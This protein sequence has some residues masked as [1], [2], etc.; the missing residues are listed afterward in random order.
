MNFL[1]AKTNNLADGVLKLADGYRERSS[2]YPLLTK[3]F[4]PFLND[5][6][7]RMVKGGA[8]LLE[9]CKRLVRL[10]KAKR[11]ISMMRWFAGCLT[12]CTASA[13]L[14]SCS[15]VIPENRA[16]RESAA[17]IMSFC[18]LAEF[19][20]VDRKVWRSI[21]HTVA[22][23]LAW[24]A[25]DTD[26]NARDRQ[27]AVVPNHQRRASAILAT[28]TEAWRGELYNNASSPK[29]GGGRR[30]KTRGRAVSI[31]AP[32]EGVLSCSPSTGRR[33]RGHGLPVDD[34][35]E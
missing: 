1:H 31:G 18:L 33:G 7:R 34:E 27:R 5:L 10:Q 30:E 24:P 28:C 15:S 22:S 8:T 4:Q 2:V 25:R 11:N 21:L 6:N 26:A 3:Q 16:A 20:R 35:V 12:I 32:Q 14:S 13:T 29:L 19:A 23:Q 9:V 17:V